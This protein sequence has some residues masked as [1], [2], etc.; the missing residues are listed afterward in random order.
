[1][2]HLNHTTQAVII[3]TLGCLGFQVTKIHLSTLKNE[4]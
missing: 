2:L 1:M 3:S 4:V